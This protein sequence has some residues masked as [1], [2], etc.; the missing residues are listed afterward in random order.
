[1]PAQ[2]LA[3][4]NWHSQPSP[5]PP[6]GQLPG[7]VTV[8]QLP[9]AEGAVPSSSS[10]ELEAAEPGLAS[11]ADAAGQPQPLGAAAGAEAA[12]PCDTNSVQ[13]ASASQRGEQQD[14]GLTGWQTSAAYNM[15]VTAMG[16]VQVLA[17]QAAQQEGQAANDW[18]LGTAQGLQ[19][20][21]AGP[22]QT[23]AQQTVE[24]GTVAAGWHQA[25]APSLQICNDDYVNDEELIRILQQLEDGKSCQQPA[26]AS[27]AGGP[28]AVAASGGQQSH[29][30][31]AVD[32]SE[33]IAEHMATVQP[34][35]LHLTAKPGLPSGSMQGLMQSSW[36]A[37]GQGCFCSGES[38]TV[39]YLHAH[40]GACNAMQKILTKHSS[41]LP[42]VAAAAGLH[43]LEKQAQQP[44]FLSQSGRVR[45]QP[46]SF[47]RSGPDGRGGRLS[48]LASST[49]HNIINKQ[50]SSQVRAFLDSV[51]CYKLLTTLR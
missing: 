40:A 37:S 26:V 41:R 23:P 50:V 32:L 7:R 24:Q 10:A 34:A 19:T 11:P 51:L 16:P 4:S 44:S 35:R 36:A 3:A 13:A 21:A 30:P 42:N 47:I 39:P 9:A 1:M 38:W 27:S 20:A 33:D 17:Q 22:V 15:Q 28:A 31:Q 12:Q 45:S 2:E 48:V 18:Q 5:T 6:A 8:S 14:A 49:T 29:G 25:T 43:G 46:G